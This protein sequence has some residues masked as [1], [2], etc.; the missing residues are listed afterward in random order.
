M[1]TSGKT[2]ELSRLEVA[3][4]FKKKTN[5]KKFGIPKKNPQ[6]TFLNLKGFLCFLLID[7]RK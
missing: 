1:L 5:E 4:A 2:T 3:N 7:F 6:I